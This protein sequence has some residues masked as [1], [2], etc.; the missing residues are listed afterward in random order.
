MSQLFRAL[1][2]PG[3]GI[4]LAEPYYYAFDMALDAQTG[5]KPVGVRVPLEDMFTERELVHFEKALQ[6]FNELNKS[7][8]DASGKRFIETLILPIPF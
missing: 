6:E 5:V 4:L 1:V 7:S 8:S 3:H 2:D